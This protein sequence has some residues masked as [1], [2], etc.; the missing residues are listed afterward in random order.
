[1]QP[2]SPMHRAPSRLPR[3]VCVRER[4]REIECVCDRERAGGSDIGGGG[5]AGIC[6]TVHS[7]TGASTSS[8]TT[9]Q[10]KAGY[11]YRGTSLIRNRAPLGLRRGG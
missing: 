4:E 2:S 9:D 3:E 5:V 10:A 7:R 8:F 6:Q 1:M 11:M